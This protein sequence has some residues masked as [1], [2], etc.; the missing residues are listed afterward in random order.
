M[1]TLCIFKLKIKFLAFAPQDN[2]DLKFLRLMQF[3]KTKQSNKDTV[4]KRKP[5]KLWRLTMLPLTIYSFHRGFKGVSSRSSTAH[6]YAG[7]L[8]A[9]D[10]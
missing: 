6:F 10:K 9:A 2:I 3:Y 7:L 1:F 5:I 8:N 4:A